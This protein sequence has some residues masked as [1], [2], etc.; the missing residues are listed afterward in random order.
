MGHMV[1]RGG[2]SNAPLKRVF[3]NFRY[4]ARAS[5][6][7]HFSIFLYDGFNV[8]PCWS[9]YFL[10]FVRMWNLSFW[11]ENLDFFYTGKIEIR[12]E[13][14]TVRLAP[15]SSTRPATDSD[16]AQQS[17]PFDKIWAPGGRSKAHTRVW[18]QMSWFSRNIDISKKRKKCELCFFRPAPFL[19]YPPLGAGYNSMIVCYRGAGLLG[20]CHLLCLHQ[21]RFFRWQN[22]IFRV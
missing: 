16:S 10:F 5:W 4:E 1:Y 6:Q 17:H 12:M 19:C 13:N 14:R 15:M 21:L 18:N 20:P 3:L 7:N 2:K 8:F 11:G 9:R 22:L